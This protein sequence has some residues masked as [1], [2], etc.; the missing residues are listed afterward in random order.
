MPQATP[1]FAESHEPDVHTS[2][3]TV[4]VPSQAHT[5]QFVQYQ[6]NADT[7]PVPYQKDLPELSSTTS[8]NPSQLANEEYAEE[9]AMDIT[10]YEP[11]G[12]AGHGIGPKEVGYQR[13][14]PKGR[15]TADRKSLTT[16]QGRG[17]SKACNECRK[18]K[19]S[20]YAVSAPIPWLITL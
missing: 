16:P 3:V 9:V 1:T 15:K 20:Y 18:S 19:V 7:V 10:V 13:A 6:F 2:P 8:T 5:G 11:L 17:R 14:T 4:K 12:N